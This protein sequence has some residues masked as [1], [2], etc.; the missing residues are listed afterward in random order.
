MNSF[1]TMKEVLSGVDA[2]AGTLKSIAGKI[3]LFKPSDSKEFH[4]EVTEGGLNLKEGEAPS[5]NVTI[6]G[7]DIILSEILSGKQD[8]VSAFLGGKI[9]V[10]GDVMLAQKI[11]SLLKK[12]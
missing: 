2:P 4:V 9:K 6:S 12:K 10:S 1:E 11:V 8:A 7:T 3:F 5:A